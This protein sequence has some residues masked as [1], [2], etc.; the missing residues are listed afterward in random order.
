MK[1]R[2]KITGLIY[3]ILEK[4]FPIFLKKTQLR[5]ITLHHLNEVNFKELEN[6]IIELKKKKWKFIS[7]NKF[8]HLIENISEI[9]GK[10][11]LITFDDGYLSQY[12]FAQNVLSKYDIKSIFFVTNDFIFNNDDENFVKKNLFPNIKINNVEKYKSMN[13]DHLK[14]LRENDHLIGAH[15]KTHSNLAKI[16]DQSKLEKEILEAADE[17]EIKLG[18]KIKNFAYTFGN[19]ESINK[20][21]IELASSRFEYIFSGMRG[22]NL[23]STRIIARDA[24]NIFSEKNINLAIL[25]GFYDKI[26]SKKISE[27]KKWI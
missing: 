12:N 24:I 26:Y 6:L 15:T 10:N 11:I 27:V 5:V 4:L 3:L 1:I 18:F 23:F 21:V 16:N 13:I 2:E 14:K 8:F 19:F 22:N 7:P 25:N 17:L 9:E 20:E